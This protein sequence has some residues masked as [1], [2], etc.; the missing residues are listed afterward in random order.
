MQIHPTPPA[1]QQDGKP[2]P[3]GAYNG[4]IPDTSLAAWDKEGGLF[5]RRRYQR[6]AWVFYGA[7]TP[8]L[9]VGIAVADAGYLANAF[10][11]FL[12]PET[13]LFVE[14]KVL[15]PFGFPNS[16][17]PN[18]TDDWK[19]K[20]F[21]ITTIN[22]LMQCKL[23]G[24]FKLQ[25]TGQLNNNG[26]SFICPSAGRPFNFTHKN[27]C[28]PTEMEV[29]YRG[30]TYKA[31]GNIGGIDFSKGYP[32]RETFW[33]WA[34]FIGATEDGTPVGMNLFRGHN[35]KYENAAWVGKERVLLSNTTFLYDKTQLL[36][37]QTWHLKTDDG[38]VE[39]EFEPYGKR[40]EKI[41]ALA[42][43]HDF[44]Q[45][46]GKFTGRIKHN[47]TWLNVTGYGPVEDHTSK[48]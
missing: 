32:P 23:D 40:A 15:L 41:N 31:S 20:N 42:L 13:G 34:S 6:K 35:D 29:T 1:L 36:D 3:Y 8:E 7:Y 48:W 17:D 14:D 11:Y 2:L 46:F 5:N 18:L 12:V 26:L 10:A 30:K 45:P 25:L 47:N 33:N 21:S 4:L 39:L 19:L 22:N 43:S 27:L 38:L 28:L 9:M 44:T 16:F 37:Q 24:K